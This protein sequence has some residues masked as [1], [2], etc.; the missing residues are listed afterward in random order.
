MR[1]NVRNKVWFP[2][3]EVCS[4]QHLLILSQKE[5]ETCNELIL[6]VFGMFANPL[7]DHISARNRRAVESVWRRCRFLLTAASLIDLF[8]YL[9]AQGK[10]EIP[11]LAEAALRW[12]I[13]RAPV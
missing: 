1:T 10:N 4:F 8:A 5:L 7:I 6:N 9:T 2:T 3:A 11:R 12:S 13:L